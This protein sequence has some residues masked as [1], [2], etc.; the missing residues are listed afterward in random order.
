MLEGHNTK[1]RG[2]WQCCLPSS[3]CSFLFYGRVASRPLV[4]FDSLYDLRLVRKSMQKS[5][6]S[7]SGIQLVPRMTSE[8]SI[9]LVTWSGSRAWTEVG[10]E[11]IRWTLSFSSAEQQD[12]KW[13]A[14][15]VGSP[16]SLHD[17]STGEIPLLLL[18]SLAASFSRP[19]HPA[20]RR[21]LKLFARVRWTFLEDCQEYLVSECDVK[22]GRPLPHWTVTKGSSNFA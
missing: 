16:R 6:V 5:W 8:N 19:S 18:W 21:I 15:S 9:G 14:S 7:W 3:S 11:L 20:R 17:G 13:E 1:F 2:Q 4:D 12:M 22:I 10:A